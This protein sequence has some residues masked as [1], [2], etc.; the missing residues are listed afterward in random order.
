MT[1]S[2]ITL[3]A[4]IGPL[5]IDGFDWLYIPDELWARATFTTV[6]QGMEID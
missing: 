1:T 5:H 4:Q 2:K 6:I 3:L